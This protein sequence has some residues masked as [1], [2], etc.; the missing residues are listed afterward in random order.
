MYDTVL[1]TIRLPKMSILV[2]GSC[3]YVT[4]AEG[5]LQLVTGSWSPGGEI[6]MGYQRGPSAMKGIN[7]RVVEWM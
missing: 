1:G 7:V 5:T 6:I 3:E 4:V 2:P